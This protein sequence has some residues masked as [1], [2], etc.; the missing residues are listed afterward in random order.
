MTNFGD[1]ICR[2]EEALDRL[3]AP[4]SAELRR[5]IKELREVLVDHRSPRFALVGRRGSGK[6][7]L[8]NA[9]FGRPVAEVGSVKSESGRARWY[10]YHGT[11]GGIE[12]L[13]TRGIHEGSAPRQEDEMTSPFD[14]IMQALTERMPDAIL[15]L[16]KAKEVDSG[17]KADVATLKAI[18]R[19]VHR[20]H[21]YHPPLLGVVTQADE[22]DPPR[23]AL[24]PDKDEDPEL[25]DEKKA[26]VVAACRH[27]LERL[28]GDSD[29]KPLVV[30]V[31]PVVAF[32]S[33]RND[34]TLRRDDRWNIDQL[35]GMLYDEVP[36]QAR[37]EL[38]RISQVRDVQRALAE[39]LVKTA[40]GIAMGI[41][42]LPLPLAD[43]PLITAAQTTMI[44][45]I[46][47]I[48]GWEFKPS[49]AA[50]FFSALGLNVG[51]ALGLR[52]IARAAARLIVPGAGS[53]VSSSVAGA[54]TWALGQAAIAWF[55]DRK[56]KQDVRLL[57]ASA[58]KEWTPG[59]L[60]ASALSGKSTTG[61]PADPADPAGGRV[62]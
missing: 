7:S 2:L 22:L 5:Q 16:C 9:I 13:D 44:S 39:T 55:I 52:E 12:I 23:V 33:F 53:L 15:F 62:G 28:E 45:G 57:Y 59:A 21:R 42:A 17:I 51:A 4:V 20:H 43:L 37:T 24:P 10:T 41:A 31:V 48:A 60:N 1:V 19:A 25:A 29:L 6:S 34:G 27:L 38:A 8:I 3:P 54:G 32:M 40:T 14:S 56:T 50:E 58:R 47:Y 18:V 11:L 36:R 30:G 61:D 26:N 49:C 35:V 46:G